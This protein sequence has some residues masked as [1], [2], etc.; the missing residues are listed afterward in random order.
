MEIDHIFLR[1]WRSSN[2][3]YNSA[4]EENNK[5][6]PKGWGYWYDTNKHEEDCEEDKVNDEEADADD[7]EVDDEDCEEVDDEEADADDAP[8]RGCVE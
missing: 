5:S 3:E 6:P 4:S 1:G 8:A 7:E 2:Q